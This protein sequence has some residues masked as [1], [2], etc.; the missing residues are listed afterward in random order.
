MS[1]PQFHSVLTLSEVEWVNWDKLYHIQRD[2]CTPLNV[3][4]WGV[5]VLS[6]FVLTPADI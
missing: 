6:V 1:I 3:H 5:F 2:E 4:P